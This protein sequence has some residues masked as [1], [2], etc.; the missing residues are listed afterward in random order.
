[1]W[2]RFLVTLTQARGICGEKTLIEKNASRRLAYRQALLA[3]SRL[4]I[5]GGGS[6]SLW[7]VPPWAGGPGF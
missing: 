3:F 4:M 1:M 7:E 6:S 5:G 2:L